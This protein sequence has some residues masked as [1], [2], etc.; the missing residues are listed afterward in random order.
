MRLSNKEQVIA[1]A[2]YCGIDA[3]K[4]SN[5]F[6]LQDG[7]CE[8]IY[9]DS[10]DDKQRWRTRY[11]DFVGWIWGNCEVHLKPES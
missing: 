2:C 11:D 5:F 4:Y 8:V 7:F 1:Y 10:N 6:N 3:Q 9:F